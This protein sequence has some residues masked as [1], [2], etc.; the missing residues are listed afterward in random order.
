[1]APRGPVQIGESPT[2]AS[3]IPWCLC[4]HAAA[5][6]A[7]AAWPYYSQQRQV[8]G[9]ES[10]VRD[11]ARHVKTY[12]ALHNTDYLHLFSAQENYEEVREVYLSQ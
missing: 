4:F 2:P 3:P 9:R 11:G 12:L 10:A 7:V 8:P 1:M 6:A 5:A